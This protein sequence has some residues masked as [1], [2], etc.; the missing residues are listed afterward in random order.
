VDFEG[1]FHLNM[2]TNPFVSFA[3]RRVAGSP[4]VSEIGGTKSTR[5][6]HEFINCYSVLE[7]IW[8][9]FFS[10]LLFSN[11]SCHSFCFIKYCR[12]EVMLHSAK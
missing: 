4:I 12:K 6:L 1:D 2:Y 8:L 7:K 5:Y 10:T 3:A 11:L 9:S